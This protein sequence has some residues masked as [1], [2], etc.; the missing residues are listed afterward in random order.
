MPE[1]KT[2]LEFDYPNSGNVSV[3]ANDE[4]EYEYFAPD[5]WAVISWGVGTAV[6]E[7]YLRT[8][9]IGLGSPFP[10]APQVGR[11]IGTIVN[12]DSVPHV[13]RFGFVLLK[14]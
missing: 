11:F 14:L 8:A 10:G 2:V 6:P 7:L 13:L 12:S 1:I 4:V 3:P 5:G 9:L